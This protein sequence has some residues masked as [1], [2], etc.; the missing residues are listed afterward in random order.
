MKTTQID[1]PTLFS[2][3]NS[4]SEIIIDL[5]DMH[6]T[7]LQLGARGI[8]AYGQT[9]VLSRREVALDISA[10]ESLL[11]QFRNNAYTTLPNELVHS[12]QWRKS[13]GWGLSQQPYLARQLFVDTIADGT[14]YESSE[15]FES[16][17]KV[18]HA[19]AA[20]GDVYERV[21]EGMS[22]SAQESIA[23]VHAG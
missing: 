19:F 21:E 10:G 15:M 14:L 4:N 13:G 20:S 17:L 1:V 7:Q 6:S 5:T 3:S 11:N 16:K 18:A 8:D 23:A 12:W 22:W 2:D 9:R